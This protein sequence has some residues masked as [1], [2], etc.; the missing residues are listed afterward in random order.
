MQAVLDW[1][2]VVVATLA[3]AVVVLALGLAFWAVAPAALGWQPTTT[4][5]GSMEPRISVGDVVVSRP[6]AS[7]ELRVGQVLLT[8]DPDH[9]GRLRFHRYAEAQAGGGIVTKGDAN[10]DADSSPVAADQVHGVGVLR[11]PL[12]GLPVTWVHEGRTAP[13]ALLGLAGVLLLA[14]TTVDRSLRHADEAGRGGEG[15][16]PRASGDRAPASRRALLD[17][18]RRTRRRHRAGALAIVVGATSIGALLPAQAVAAPFRATTGTTGTWAA[19]TLV[20]PS[21]VVCTNTQNGVVITFEPQGSVAQP[22]VGGHRLVVGGTPDDAVVPATTKSV[23]YEK[24]PLLALGARTTIS[25]QAVAGTQWTST[26]STAVPVR[27]T[28][29]LG[30]LRG[31]QCG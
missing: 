23:T 7:T 9:D 28:S 29:V 17:H 4:M 27:V 15:A 25:V 8:D 1:A 10:P 5:S 22:P 13:L 19:A 18:R 14:L 6:V 21:D 30:L 26:P 11:V 2:R 12:V 24:V 20:P 16:G 31:V 3:R